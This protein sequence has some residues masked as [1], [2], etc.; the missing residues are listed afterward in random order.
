MNFNITDNKQQQNIPTP[1]FLPPDKNNNKQQ[2]HYCCLNDSKN[3]RPKKKQTKAT[4]TTLTL[5]HCNVHTG[6]TS[7]T[8]CFS[9][10][11][12][13]EG[14]AGEY[15]EV[16]EGCCGLIATVDCNHITRSITHC[17][18]VQNRPPFRVSRSFPGDS[19]LR[20][21]RADDGDV[22]RWS[23]EAFYRECTQHTRGNAHTVSF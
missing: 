4:T 7:N 2:Q 23:S 22:G 16:G 10:C 3:T 12:H 14:V 5:H 9:E 19:N 13:I 6:S 18:S 20:S 11:G 1:T 17:H 8:A 21:L 15:I